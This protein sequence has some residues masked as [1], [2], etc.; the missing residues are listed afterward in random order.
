M[1]KLNNEDGQMYEVAYDPELLSFEHEGM[2]IRNPFLS[3]CGRF[4]VDPVE[5]YGF[6]ESWTGGG[7]K[8]LDKALPDGGFIRLTDESGMHIPDESDGD[9]ALIGRFNAQGEQVAC[10]SLGEVRMSHEME[11]DEE[12][13]HAPAP[14]SRGLRM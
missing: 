1:Q 9:D 6:T 8:A 13:A 7:C 4:A 2:E 11:M 14:T 12:P 5:A 10:C 3:D